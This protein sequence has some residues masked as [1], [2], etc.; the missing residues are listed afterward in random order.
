MRILK[1]FLSLL[2]AGQFLIIGSQQ[3]KATSPADLISGVASGETISSQ[4]SLVIHLTRP[5]SFGSYVRLQI[6]NFTTR[7]IAIG[8]DYTEPGNYLV[9]FNPLDSF[10]NI[11]QSDSHITFVN[12]INHQPLVP[13]E[14]Y[15][16]LDYD[17][18]SESG[19][20]D[21]TLS[22]I[23]SNVTIGVASASP[24]LV[25]PTNNSVNIGILPISYSLPTE[26][27]SGSV[28]IRIFNEMYLR[29][30]SL[31]AIDRG[32]HSLSINPF[33]T[34]ENSTEHLANEATSTESTFDSSPWTS[35]LPIGTYSVAIEYQ[36]LQGNNIARQIA[37]GILLTTP[38]NE[39][40]FSTTGVKDASGHCTDATVGHYVDSPGATQETPCPKGQ[41]AS[42]PAS[43]RCVLASPNTYV[44][45][46]GA[47]TSTP[48]PSK[49]T[50][51]AGSDSI[52]D[53]KKPA[54]VVKYCNMKK[55]KQATASCIAAA[56]S[57][58]IPAKAKVTITVNKSDKKYCVVKNGKVL[59]KLK[60]ICRVTLK[61]QPKKGKAITYSSR[62]RVS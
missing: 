62:I 58:K 33:D 43:W 37:Q 2:I 5:V 41:Y 54:A 14:Y 6:S 9:S 12:G 1:I 24:I 22:Q 4:T 36:D 25:A 49:Y 59:G 3:A 13:G 44:D 51:A 60:G 32:L 46:L 19:G 10:A 40:T 17:A 27:T 16:Q 21:D 57:K 23:I 55:N 30:I 7:G 47:S 26:A 28:K 50:S 18:P 53:C 42:A 39:G 52:S 11:Q 20:R 29:I 31:T 35:G 34:N 38:C 48:C 56:A 61:V 15:F 45:T 8:F